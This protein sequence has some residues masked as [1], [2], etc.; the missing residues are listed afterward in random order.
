MEIDDAW[1]SNTLWYLVTNIG[2]Q[3]KTNERW[4]QA[5]FLS[6]KAV[7]ILRTS[8]SFISVSLNP[9]VSNSTTFLPSRVNGLECC[10][11]DVQEERSIP[12]LKSPDPL[13]AR[14]ANYQKDGEE[15]RMRRTTA[16]R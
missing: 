5:H 10:I 6:R 11:S 2:K 12:T 1:K 4:D 9:G 13:A 8:V 15:A 3:R 14:S 16:N 7:I